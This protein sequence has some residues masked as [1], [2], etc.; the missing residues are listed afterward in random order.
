VSTRHIALPRL[1][2]EHQY[3]RDARVPSSAD[4]PERN[5]GWR[6]IPVPLTFDDGLVI[7][8]TRSDRKTGR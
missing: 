8:D 7:F 4:D 5:E 6:C 1:V 2:I 3:T